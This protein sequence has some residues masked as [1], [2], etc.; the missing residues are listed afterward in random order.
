MNMLQDVTSY[1]LEEDFRLFCFMVSV[2]FRNVATCL[3][4]C[5]Q[6]SWNMFTDPVDLWV[7]SK[8]VLNFLSLERALSRDAAAKCKVNK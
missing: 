1:N 6:G 4:N 8:S 5:A 3:K 2:F 7:S